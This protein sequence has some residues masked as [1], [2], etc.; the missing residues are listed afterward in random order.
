MAN[1][2]NSNIPHTGYTY[3][4]S[5]SHREIREQRRKARILKAMLNIQPQA[6]DMEMALLGSILIGGRD[7][8]DKVH[9]QLSPETFYEHK[10]AVI[11][12][13]IENTAFFGRDID[14][15]SVCNELKMTDKLE[16]AGGAIYL[17]NLSTQVASPANA[18]Y[19]AK[20]IA[21]KFKARQLLEHIKDIDKEAFSESPNSP[22]ANEN[23][24]VSLNDELASIK[25][26]A[27]HLLTKIEKFETKF[28]ATTLK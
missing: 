12:K 5:R 2:N 14:L 15:L 3:T 11:Y 21:Q 10:H 26:L 7:V 28:N 24:S 9:E 20:I 16:E 1:N 27:G 19:Y 6:V 25:G 23:R 4:S 17:A 22:F 13:S 8:Y 18:E